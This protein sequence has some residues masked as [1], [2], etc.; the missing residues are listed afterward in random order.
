MNIIN[1]LIQTIGGLG[2]FVLGM[3]M[4]TEGLQMSAGRRIKKILSAVSVNRVVGCITGAGVTAMVQSSSAT[5]VMLI[6]F[7]SAGLM[8]LQQA[9]GVILGANV[10][11]TVTAQLIAFKLT[12][13]A[14]PAIAIGVS[15]KFFTKKKKYRYIGEVILGFGLLF[16]GM[17][18]MKHGLSPI[19]ADPAFFEF[20]TKFDPSSIGGL[21][22]CVMVGAFLTIM[23][24]SSSATIGLTMTLATQGLL[25]FPG[26]M[27][28]VLGENI[29]TTITAELAT[30]GATNINAHRAAR[31]HTMFNVI[32]VGL[33]LLIFPYFVGIIEFITGQLGAGPATQVVNGEVVNVARYIAN[34]HT[35]FNVLNASV[36]LIFLPLLI[37][38]AI[39]LSPKHEEPEDMYRLP[40]FGDRFMDTPIAALAKA[41]SEIIRMSEIA[42]ITFKNTINCI[43]D[44]NYN[45]LSKWKRIENHL[46]AMQ[47]EI[48]AYLTKIY[49]SEVNESE[50]KEISSLMR[51]TNNIERI[52]DS[53]EN[54][55]QLMEDYIENDLKFTPAAM[56]DIK[57]I[58]GQVTNFLN[59]VTKGMQNH[60]EN[61]MTEADSLE[62]SIDHM[63]ENMRQ[64]HI[65]RLR[66]GDCA[67]DPGLVF[68]DMLTNFEKIGDYCFNIAEAVAG[69]K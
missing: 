55:A 28:L 2:L 34:G 10:G 51:M 3:K 6:G 63:R 4:M 32:G 67:L 52:G 41:R 61:F 43:E 37:K 48:T 27:A 26:A 33:M 14:L 5:T 66:S 65:S 69:L 31:A 7:V 8:T 58:S 47:K 16:F 20:F 30:I 17:T 46:D 15:L 13:V 18:V 40:D 25:T 44:R 21:L 53:V 64:D 12:E 24:Q 50:A 35:I 49:Q 42:I 22:L 23:V 60:N 9:V 62:N 45:R 19:K 39:K 1:V 29:G 54:I 38:V 68:I 57:K 59:L 11:T 56:T 36:F